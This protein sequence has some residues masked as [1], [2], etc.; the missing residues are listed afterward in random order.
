MARRGSLATAG[1]P[2][3]S[4]V[5]AGMNH[6][7]S[8]TVSTST[9]SDGVAAQDDIGEAQRRRV[10][11]AARPPVHVD[12]THHALEV[13]RHDGGERAGDVGDP[14]AVQRRR[15]RQ[16]S[17]DLVRIIELE[18]GEQVPQARRHSGRSGVQELA[19]ELD[20]GQPTVGPHPGREIDRGSALAAAG[21][22]FAH[23]S[24]RS[25]ARAGS[26]ICVVHRVTSHSAPSQRRRAR[27]AP[28]YLPHAA[29]CGRGR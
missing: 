3:S 10:V 16:P 5:P 22:P 15:D 27:L 19:S 23:G 1:R 26:G 29:P 7:F 2:A 9:S 14:L 4:T 17:R 28:R 6:R 20:D 24:P 13:V 18:P 12:D 11:A 21:L 25:P 8:V